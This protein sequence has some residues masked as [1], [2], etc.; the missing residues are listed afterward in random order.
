MK[1]S[2][3]VNSLYVWNMGHVRVVHIDAKR[4]SI[5]Y[6]GGFSSRIVEVDRRDFENSAKLIDEYPVR[7]SDNKLLELAKED[8]PVGVAGI[9]SEDE[10]LQI[11]DRN[12]FNAGFQAGLEH[13]NTLAQHC[14]GCISD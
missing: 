11:R 2:I 12:S 13:A 14:N 10:I 5:R 7:L 3:K 6:S 9:I 1:S 8:E 4:I